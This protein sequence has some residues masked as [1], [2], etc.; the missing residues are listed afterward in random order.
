MSIPRHAPKSGGNRVPSSALN[1]QNLP[2]RYNN[3]TANHSS[4]SPRPG[5]DADAASCA[6]Q[7]AFFTPMNDAGPRASVNKEPDLTPRD[8]SRS[9]DQIN[10]TDAACQDHRSVPHRVASTA[11]EDP[12]VGD[13]SEVE[14][15]STV[16]H[17]L[18]RLCADIETAIYTAKCTV[19]TLAASDTR[20]AL[21]R[22]RME[23]FTQKS[24]EAE[25]ATRLFQYYST[26]CNNP[27]G[28]KEVK[29]SSPPASSS[30][31]LG[32]DGT[33]P[34]TDAS[35]G[36]SICAFIP[37]AL[38]SGLSGQIHGVERT[39]HSNLF[40]M[41]GA[42]FLLGMVSF[43]CMAYVP[44]IGQ[45]DVSPVDMVKV[46]VTH[47][48]KYTLSVYERIFNACMRLHTIYVACTYGCMYGQDSCVDAVGQGYGFRSSGAFSM[49]SLAYVLALGVILATHS[50]VC[51]AYYMLPLD[52]QGRKCIPG[53]LHLSYNNAIIYLYTVYLHM[54]MPL[55]VYIHTYIHTCVHM[56][57]HYRLGLAAAIRLEGGL[58]DA[59]WKVLLSV[60]YIA[61]YTI[62]MYMYVCMYVC[63]LIYIYMQEPDVLF[64]YSHI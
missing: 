17:K 47:I 54:I 48:V 58:G 16:Y 2:S 33:A 38:Y 9:S 11:S 20:K 4:G 44:T 61:Y 45:R 57:R 19:A 24:P 36:L 63:M 55:C 32:S 50:A 18:T 52:D 26:Q 27:L 64:Q 23:S 7:R 8:E 28:R 13:T 60:I 12:G 40:W 22:I 14:S 46:R 39:L 30:S 15:Y 6:P 5:S 29:P 43:I 42:V 3:S 37:P 34:P 59:S 51:M 35:D 1:N 53:K 31:S 49:V 10:T 21:A 62:C 41:R 25:Y 56:Y